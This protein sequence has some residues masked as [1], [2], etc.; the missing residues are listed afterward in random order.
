MSSHTSCGTVTFTLPLCLLKNGMLTTRSHN[1][2]QGLNTNSLETK[3]SLNLLQKRNQQKIPGPVR[4]T[5]KR[6]FQKT[7]LLLITTCSNAQRKPQG[8]SETST[9][10]VGQAEEDAGSG[11]FLCLG[12]LKIP[13]FNSCLFLYIYIYIYSFRLGGK[14][15]HWFNATNDTMF[16]NM[17]SKHLYW[18]SG[19]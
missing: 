10:S 12:L 15:I 7:D 9:T 19:C 17:A 13:A 2:N 18:A 5:R 1:K 14:C 3:H 8:P 6:C 16:L 11:R 4:V